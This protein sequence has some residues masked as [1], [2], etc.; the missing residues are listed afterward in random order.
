MKKI[1]ETG[2]D[3]KVFDKKHIEQEIINYKPY[4]VINDILDTKKSLYPKIKKANIYT[5]N[6]EDLGSGA[7]IS[8]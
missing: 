4:L 8:I 3:Y 5:V 7:I 1:S 2:Y 6:F